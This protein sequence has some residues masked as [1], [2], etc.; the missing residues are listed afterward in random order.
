MN[1]KLSKILN[2]LILPK[3]ETST[4]ERRL[5]FAIAMSI[6][7]VA[8]TLILVNSTDVYQVIK[9]SSLML[10]IILGSMVLVYITGIPQQL[11]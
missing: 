1:D 5:A 8:I 2:S 3:V 10:M 9:Y 6:A 7:T 11:T 4:N